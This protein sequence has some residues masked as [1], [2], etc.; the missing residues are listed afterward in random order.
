MSDD[1][2]TPD[3]PPLPSDPRDPAAPADTPSPPAAAVPDDA[4]PAAAPAAPPAP[5]PPVVTYGQVP[6]TL[7]EVYYK[8]G[9][10]ILLT[11]ITCGIWFGVYA[12]RTHGDLKR[13]KGDGLGELAGL[14]LGLFISP[15]VMFTIPHE[16]EQMYQR[17]GRDS[18]VS[19]LW[20]LWFLLPL[21]G[22]IIWFVR[23]QRALNE[24]WISKGS[25]SAA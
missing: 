20:G 15:V 3:V 11:I 14:L 16:T 19:T 9:V 25:Q 12:Y 17:E 22:W 10:N 5:P 2:S 8:V 6:P 13:Y 18:P 4:A 7:N 23:V 24:F 21:V 1:P